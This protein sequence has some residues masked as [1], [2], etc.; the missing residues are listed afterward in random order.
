M[1]VRRDRRRPCPLPP[2]CEPSC[3]PPHRAE[4]VGEAADV[5]A[6]VAVIRSRLPTSVLSTSTSPAAAAIR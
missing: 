5:D 1:T 4:I 3:S 2:G 6:A